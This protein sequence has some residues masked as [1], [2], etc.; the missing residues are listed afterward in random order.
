MPPPNDLVLG[1]K[2]HIIFNNPKTGRFEQSWDKRNVYY[3][4]W[5][6]LIASQFADFN[7][8]QHLSISREIRG[9]LHFEHFKLLQNEFGIKF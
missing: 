3:H 4:P 5:K 1:H 2:E 7:P 8:Q 9:K 6:T